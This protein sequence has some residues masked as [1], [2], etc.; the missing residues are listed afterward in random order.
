MERSESFIWGK[1]VKKGRLCLSLNAQVRPQGEV[2][3]DK[4]GVI[5]IFAAP[6][7]IGTL[8]GP[9]SVLGR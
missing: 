3:V 8:P 2:R 9:M 1:L 7:L 4:K 5:S 6:I